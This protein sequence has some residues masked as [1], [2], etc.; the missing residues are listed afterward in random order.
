MREMNDNQKYIPVI[1]H[2][3]GMAVTN[4]ACP[5]CGDTTGVTVSSRPSDLKVKKSK[6]MWDSESYTW[7]QAGCSNGHSF[8]VGYK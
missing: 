2:T 5:Y 6:S 7:V 1:P 3:G 8:T 4:V